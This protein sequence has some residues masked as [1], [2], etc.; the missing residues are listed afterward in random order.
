MILIHYSTDFYLVFQAKKVELL[1]TGIQLKPL[2]IKII[3]IIVIFVWQMTDLNIDFI[4][5]SSPCCD[6]NTTKYQ[7]T[8]CH[9]VEQFETPIVNRHLFQ[10]QKTADRFPKSPKK[11]SH[12]GSS[13][14]SY[15]QLSTRLNLSKNEECSP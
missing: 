13:L 14:L 3:K 6:E 5:H 1:L 2:K 9:L 4:Q 11:L 7:Q 10:L 15:F 8:C 12:C